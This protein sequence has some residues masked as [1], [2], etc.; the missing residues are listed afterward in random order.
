MDSTGLI[1]VFFYALWLVLRDLKVDL[2]LTSNLSLSDH[3]FYLAHADFTE[4]S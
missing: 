3:Q 4:R 2:P 1:G